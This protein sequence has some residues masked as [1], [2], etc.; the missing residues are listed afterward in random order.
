MI[1][2]THD[3]GGIRPKLHKT[4]KNHTKK[5]GPS[6]GAGIFGIF[7]FCS[8]PTPNPPSRRAAFSA[9]IHYPGKGPAYS[10]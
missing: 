5:E 1:D 2:G 4:N 8:L 10:S 7:G 3:Q 9:F 6:V